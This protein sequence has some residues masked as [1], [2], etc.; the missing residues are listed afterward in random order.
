M[1]LTNTIQDKTQDYIYKKE[2]ALVIRK[3]NV[4]VVEEDYVN[5]LFVKEV[6]SALKLKVIRAITLEDAILHP[7]MNQ[8]IDLLIVN[9]SLTCAAQ[10]S[11]INF[12]REIYSVPVVVVDGDDENCVR[13][14]EIVDWVDGIISLNTDT[15]HFAET[16]Y[17]MLNK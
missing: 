11:V 9:I 8:S 17:D 1:N 13:Y 3:Y 6:L 10:M 2:N 12:L 16:I 15:E 14:Q 5:Y 7:P 4:L